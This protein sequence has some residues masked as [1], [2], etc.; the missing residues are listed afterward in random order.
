MVTD[1][2]GQLLFCSLSAEALLA[3][4]Q[5][6]N[7]LR[8]RIVARDARTQSVLIQAI[9]QAV[10]LTQGGEN[11]VLT[12]TGLTSGTGNTL[13]NALTGNSGNNTFTGLAGNDTLNGGAG[14]DI[15]IGGTGADTYQF[16]VGSGVDTVQENDST[17]SVVDGVSLSGSLTQA[18]LQFSKVGNNLEML[19]A[20][21]TDKMIFKDWYLG[22]AFHVEQFRFSNGSVLTDTQAQ[23]LVGAMAAFA[24]PAAA[25]TS[26]DSTMT[27]STTMR[28]G[29]AV[30][31][32]L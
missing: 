28:I 8:G 7:V 2:N 9:R 14:T 17:A 26:L 12:G 4:R 1:Q 18:N 6:L 3:D 27:S 16:G 10:E 32:L 21:G 23:G 5:V 30:S 25:S 15:L 20:G 22:S 13:A 24:A 29:I 31:G 11:L 19:I